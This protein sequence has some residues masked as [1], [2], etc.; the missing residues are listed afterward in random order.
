M[1]ILAY[2]YRLLPTN[3]IYVRLFYAIPKLECGHTRAKGIRLW[4]FVYEQYRNR[5]S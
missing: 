3:L 4:A 2:R 1:L 5:T